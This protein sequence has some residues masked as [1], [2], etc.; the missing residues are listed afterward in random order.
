VYPLAKLETEASANVDAM[1]TA[2]NFFMDNSS[3]WLLGPGGAHVA[4]NDSG[5]RQLTL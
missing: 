1:A 5:V 3:L 2:A 4:D